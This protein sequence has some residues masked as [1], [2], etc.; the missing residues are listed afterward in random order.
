MEEAVGPGLV[1][2]LPSL[3]ISHE[4]IGE[5]AAATALR[6]QGVFGLGGNLAAG[7][8]DMLGRRNGTRGIR[9][10]VLEGRVNLSLNVVV[11]Y[12]V[13]IPE[14]AQHL[15]ERVKTEV[16]RATG[17]GVRSVDIHI[18]GVSFPQEDGHI[19]Q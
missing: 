11:R 5:I 9:V 13:R 8:G 16:E 19:E 6:V 17:L 7:L 14:V 10:E 3:H 2:A 18:H 12:G 15:Q 1:P 4:V